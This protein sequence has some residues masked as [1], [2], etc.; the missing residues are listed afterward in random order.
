[1]IFAPGHNSMLGSA[2]PRDW[3]FSVSETARELRG[4]N[5]DIDLVPK[6]GLT[7]K[8]DPCPWNE[9]VGNTAH[10]CTVKNTSICR[11]FRGIRPVD[12]VLCAFPAAE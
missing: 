1:M 2:W 5:M 12:A 10:R 4:A 7:W 8:Q 11:Y 3:R 6:P 9:A